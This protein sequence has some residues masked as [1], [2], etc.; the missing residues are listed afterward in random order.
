MEVSASAEGCDL[1]K[2]VDDVNNYSYVGKFSRI[3]FTRRQGSREREKKEE[4]KSIVV[5]PLLAVA[6]RFFTIS[7]AFS[8]FVLD[9][10]ARALQLRGCFWFPLLYVRRN[11]MCWVGSSHSPHLSI[12]ADLHHV[13][14]SFIF[15]HIYLLALP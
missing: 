13:A 7:A 8:N 9:V 10:F 4:K 1:Q 5:R 6:R 11:S 15:Y 2:E 3:P 12:S 14:L